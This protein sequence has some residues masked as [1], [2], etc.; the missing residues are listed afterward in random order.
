MR[1]L[2]RGVF[3]SLTAALLS[4]GCA[5]RSV[6]PDDPPPA[7][8]PA[9]ANEARAEDVKAVARGNNAFA[10]DLYRALPPGDGGNLFFSP[11]SVS[12]ALGMTYAG[13][14]GD[15]AKDMAKTLRYPFEGD[16]LHLGY[17]GLIGKLTGDARPAGVRLSVANA[18]WG[19]HPY[20]QAFLD[21]N[22]DYYAADLRKI[23]LRG[24]EP[25][26]NKW[27]EER[28]AGRIKD[29]LAPGSLTADSVLVLTNA[30]YFKGTW[31]YRFKENDTAEEP[32]RVPGG[33]DVRVK[34]MHQ[35]ATLRYFNFDWSESEK[36][37]VLVLPYKGGEL[38]MVLV[39][40]KAADGLAA[41]ERALTPDKLD[42]ILGARSEHNVHVSL[43]R[44]TVK[45]KSV[46]LNDPLEKMGMGRAFGSRADFSGIY[47]SPG[48]IW[49]GNVVHQAFVE[50]N[51]EGSEAAA[52]TAVEVEK[53]SDPSPQPG[54]TIEFRADHPFLF[55]IR[56]E[57]TGAILFMGR[58]SNPT[59]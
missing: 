54:R 5:V 56:D 39:L 43:P 30:V 14:K 15:T 12:T 7:P 52:A 33:K 9:K 57:R 23:E 38:S 25:A 11:L 6:K 4:A 48:D 13:A 41:F 19:P 2:L 59:P 55:L 35:T 31:Q 50:V 32:F 45:G 17:A 28:T 20:N 16:R 8:R 18:L 36:G 29:L 26:I 22:R 46:S 21:A 24:A 58:M 10:L 34:M 3:L 37:Q 44:F 51:E 27:A 47:G 42:L 53:G 1:H 49:I 40:P